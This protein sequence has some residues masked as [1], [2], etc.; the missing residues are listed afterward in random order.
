V[1]L[2]LSDG[3]CTKTQGSFRLGRFLKQ[4]VIEILLLKTNTIWVQLKMTLLL[5]NITKI[6][7]TY[8]TELTKLRFFT[9]CDL[10]A[11]LLDVSALVLSMLTLLPSTFFFNVGFFSTLFC[12]RFSLA[13]NAFRFSMEN[14]MIGRASFEKTFGLLF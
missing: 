14:S 6:V 13:F 12:C 1:L 3:S 9:F 2:L 5:E 4:S 7:S 10:C 8:L 11:A